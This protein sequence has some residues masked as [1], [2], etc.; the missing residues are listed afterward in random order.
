MDYQDTANAS[1]N[2]PVSIADDAAV[3]EQ[4]LVEVTGEPAADNL[5]LTRPVGAALTWLALPVLGEQT[6]LML[7]GLVDTFLAGTV[8][9]EATAAIG[10]A[11]Q[12]GW[13]ANLLFGFIATGAT[14]LVAR[15]AGMGRRE[16]SNHF[17]NQ[18]LAAAAIMGAL[19]YALIAGS[20]PLLP[21]ML[22]W[23]A[24]PA[25]IA[26]QYLRID[27]AGY[28]LASMTAVAAACW[29]G[30][31]DTRTPLY[32]MVVVNV[33]NVYVSAA[34]RFG[35]W[36]MPAVGVVGIAIGTLTARLLGG[37]IVIGLLLRGQSGI[38][39]RRQELRFRADSMRR[40]LRVG[41]PAGLDGTF[42]WL[43]QLGF[44]LI[45]SRLAA[46]AA[47][48]ATVAAHY[49]GIKVESL[50]YLPAF[51]W[52][53]AAATLV[54]QSLGAGDRDRARR[55]GHLAAMHCAALCLC[56]GT[57]YFLGARWIFACFNTTGDYEAVAAIGVP[58]M[59][60]LAFFQVPLALMIVY[61]N[62]LRGA[63][64]TRYPLLFTL[65]GM[66]IVRLPLAYF[67][68]IVLE[69][70]L[71]GAWVGMFADMTARAVLSTWR[72]ASGRWMRVQV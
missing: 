26:V 25:R 62:A 3:A 72:F 41:A 33:V 14:A 37:L 23:D 48:S 21:R 44:L 52:G 69:G 43:G 13:L 9:K 5:L 8:G 22:R 36:P 30:M 38:R 31:G 10:L 35:I 42:L 56:M 55:S 28:L 32:V 20:A 61:T 67:C 16:R 68:G 15:H 60:A 65:I 63:G 18:A 1:A 29:R 49:V 45:I 6:L 17:S 4:P 58:A 19:T 50:S 11:S 12:V 57:F 70:G 53:T 71:I 7:V 54:G 2:R 64:D 59:R 34:L 27:S 40:L 51:A 24:E 47:Q 46:G 66:V 39:F